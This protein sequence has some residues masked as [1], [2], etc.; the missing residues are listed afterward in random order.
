LDSFHLTWHDLILELLRFLASATC[1][2]LPGIFLAAGL[3]LGKNWLQT[4]IHGSC[5]G[6]AAAIYLASLISQ[7]DLR[8]FYPI[9]AGLGLVTLVY[10]LRSRRGWQPWEVDR[11]GSCW[12]IFIL[13]LVAVSRYAIALPQDLPQGWDPSF[14]AILARKIQLAHH[15]IHDWTPFES[16]ALNYPTGSQTLVAVLSTICGLP[17]QIVFKDLIPLLG[18]LT[19]G[20]IFLL[21]RNATGNLT[22]A[23]FGALAYGIWANLGSIDYYHWGGLPN[24]LAMLLFLSMLVAWLEPW[25]ARTRLAVMSIAY[26]SAILTHHHVM[27]SSAAILVVTLLWPAKIEKWTLLCAAVAA[28]LL[29]AFFLIP[30]AAKITTVASTRVFHS[31]EQPMGL[32]GLIPSFGYAFLLASIL[33]IAIA[34]KQRR[35]ISIHP[36]APLALVTLV[37]LYVLCEYVWPMFNGS[38]IFTPSRFPTDASSFLAIF[39]GVALAVLQQRLRLPRTVLVPAMLLL[40]AAQPQIWRPRGARPV[41]SPGFQ[42]ACDW[43]RRNTSARTYVI[44]DKDISDVDNQLSWIPYLTWRRAAYTP[45]P[46]SE[47]LDKVPAMRDRLLKLMSGNAP[48]KSPVV[49]ILG[50]NDSADFPTLWRA[51]SGIRVVQVWPRPQTE[52]LRP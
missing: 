46:D 15:A 51:P 29:D 6:L 3:R 7:I 17:V 32:V 37:I 25:P 43:V 33:G 22:A 49:A 8:W 4:C 1:V 41:E 23:I 26:A 45:L 9:W 44:C 5:L 35:K 27:L 47:P 16:V 30:Y 28:A 21:T 52:S 18:V 48:G 14:H 40:S 50:P 31:G 39:A 19:T 2:L 20:Q 38:T 13:L 11:S 42:A 36:V 10:L 12:L 34:I 24:E